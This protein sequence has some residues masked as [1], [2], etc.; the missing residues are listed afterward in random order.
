MKA[1]RILLASLAIFA[2]AG[3]WVAG[4]ILPMAVRPVQ[5]MVEPYVCSEGWH[6]VTES[7]SCQSSQGSGT[8]TCYDSF[9]VSPDGSLK[10]TAW[11]LLAFNGI[12]L[13]GMMLF[14]G[15][16]TLLIVRMAKSGTRSP[17]P[18]YGTPSTLGSSMGSS[19]AMSQIPGLSGSQIDFGS[20]FTGPVQVH[21]SDM[22]VTLDEQ[23]EKLEKLRQ[24]GLVS[25]EQY[26]Q[27]VAAI[28]QAYDQMK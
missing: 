25:E 6:L 14:M 16:M 21:I 7:R 23:L 9:C 2:C 28:R 8:A 11:R 1:L 10:L 19:P 27:I 4:L 12:S 24:T 18:A 20:G 15:A 3:L 22:K 26:Q 5:A 13:V 17:V